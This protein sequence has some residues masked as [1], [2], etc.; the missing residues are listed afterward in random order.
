[1]NQDQIPFNCWIIFFWM[2][3][4]ILLMIYNIWLVFGFWPLWIMPLWTFVY[5]VFVWMLIFISIKYIPV[6]C[7]CKSLL[8]CLTLCHPVDCSPPGSFVH[9]I[10]QERILD[11]AGIS[12][13]RGSSRPMIEPESLASPALQVDSLPLALPGKF[14]IGLAWAVCLPQS[15][16]LGMR[17][18]AWKRQT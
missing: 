15:S 12:S 3:H 4:Y 9:G 18:A 8:L 1:M 14:S 6:L 5:D 13:S 11:W 2:I 16:H 17:D 10:L 7:Y